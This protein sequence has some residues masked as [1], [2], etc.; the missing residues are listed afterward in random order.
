MWD[1]IISSPP[2][3]QDHTELESPIRLPGH[4]PT[5]LCL[6]NSSHLVSHNFRAST[7]GHE[8]KSH[9]SQYPTAHSTFT[10]STPRLI[11]CHRHKHSA[12]KFELNW[13]YFKKNTKIIKATNSGLYNYL[14]FQCGSFEVFFLIHLNYFFK[15]EFYFKYRAVRKRCLSK[16]IP[17]AATRACPQP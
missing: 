4:L 17:R 2:S 9:S 14:R 7:W 13:H 12:T 3:L 5:V 11:K 1:V 15:L 6:L 10:G 16:R 8:A